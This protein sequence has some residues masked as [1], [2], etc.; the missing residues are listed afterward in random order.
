MDTAHLAKSG[1]ADIAGLIRDFGGVIDNV[2]AKDYEQGHFRILGR[3]SLDFTPIMAA[4]GD[5][6]YRGWLCV[7]EESPASLA[8]GLRV[9]R[10]YLYELLGI[11]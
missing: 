4:L 3:G 7:D 9:S 2:H 1:V 5:V 8:E 6:G 11:A 10:E